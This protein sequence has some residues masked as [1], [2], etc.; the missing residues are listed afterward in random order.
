MSISLSTIKT[1][2]RIKPPKLTVMGVAGIGKTTFAA[3][4][5]DPI[6]LFTEE[7][8]GKLDVA[9]FE[10]RPGDP[11]LRS[12]L[13]VMDC[14]TSLYTEEHQ[15]KTVVID[16]LDGLEPLLW[17][18]TADA[19]N[20]S[21]IE[22]VGGG[23]GKGYI[24]ALD[25]ARKLFDGLEALRNEKGMA[26]VLLAHTQTKKFESPD[27][28]S[29]DRYQLR[30]QDRFANA[31]Y[32]WTDVLLFAQWKAHVVK[33]Q[34]KRKTD[35]RTRGVG[36]GERIMYTEERPAWWAKNRYGLPLELPLDWP[37]FQNAMASAVAPKQPA[38]GADAPDTDKED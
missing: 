26:V 13:E 6:F 27:S 29:Y 21:N 10:P 2:V 30:L 15:Y 4:A 7:G 1:G 28:Q 38:Q 9:R 36:S 23:Y 22:E 19:H 35:V 17:A 34:G 12:W 24:H 20:V 33:D 18:H 3:G 16:T 25:H 8:Q 31:T 32:E 14:V 5:P 37:T 11:V